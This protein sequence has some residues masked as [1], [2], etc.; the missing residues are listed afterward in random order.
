MRLHR[1]CKARF[2]ATGWDGEGARRVGGRWNLRGDAVVYTAPNLALAAWETFVH[3]DPGL[4]PADLVQLAATLPDDASRRE[5]SPEE[6]PAG[7]RRYP[8]PARLAELGSAWIRA[9]ETLLLVV[10]SAVIADETCV[11]VNPAH[12]E[13]GRLRPEPPKPFAFDPRAWKR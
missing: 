1:L 7:F 5:L 11:L 8:A 4:I 12:P 13:F 9:R 2:A 3:V 10:P 6:L